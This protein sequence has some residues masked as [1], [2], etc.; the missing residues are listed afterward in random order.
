M[1]SVLMSHAQV[2][3]IKLLPQALVTSTSSLS[4]LGLM[5]LQEL[6]TKIMIQAP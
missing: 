5:V 2:I 3:P 6:L 4:L 1:Y